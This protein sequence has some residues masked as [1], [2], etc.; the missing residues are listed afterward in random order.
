MVSQITGVLLVSSTVCSK[1]ISKLWVT[2]I[3]EENPPVAGGFPSQRASNAENV[4]IWWRH[5]AVYCHDESDQLDMFA[6]VTNMTYYIV[7]L[8]VSSQIVEAVRLLVGGFGRQPYTTRLAWR[9]AI[10]TATQS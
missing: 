5:R 10:Y 9:P 7:I 4:P 6:I 2:G 1:E 3:C 8:D